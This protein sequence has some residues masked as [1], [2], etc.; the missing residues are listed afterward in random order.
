MSK[1]EK[2]WE[3]RTPGRGLENQGASFKAAGRS[4]TSFIIMGRPARAPN[5]LRR[6][7]LARKKEKRDPTDQ[8]SAEVRESKRIGAVGDHIAALWGSIRPEDPGGCLS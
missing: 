7:H 5:Y 8:G 6:L 3:R 4:R 1:P 2:R